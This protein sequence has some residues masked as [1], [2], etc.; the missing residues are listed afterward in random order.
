MLT[1]PFPP[2]I[3]IGPG[4]FLTQIGGGVRLNPLE[5]SLR[6][7]FGA[8]PLS[9][10]GPF[11]ATVN[12]RA[13]VSFGDPITFTFDGTGSLLEIALAE[14]HFVVNTDGYASLRAGARFDFEI[15]SGRGNI[16]VTLDGPNKQFLADVNGDVE[17]AGQSFGGVEALA[18][19]IGFGGCY[20]LLVAELGFGYRWGDSLPDLMFPSCDLS[21]YKPMA[22]GGTGTPPPGATGP[23]AAGSTFDVKPGTPSVSIQVD[24]D[25][26]LPQVVL[27]D[28]DG[29]RIEPLLVQPPLPT[30]PEILK[31]L[32]AMALPVSATRE[33]I[34]I[35]GPKA[36]TWR[37]EPA[38]GAAA[39]RAA[40]AGARPRA[41]AAAIAGLQI[42]T[43]LPAPT[44]SARVSGNG[45]SRSLAYRATR[46][47]GL[48]VTFI[49]RG[50][51]GTRVIGRTRPAGNGTVQFSTGDLPAGRRTVVAVVQQDGAPRLRK[52]VASYTA[53]APPRPA[54]VGGVAVQRGGGGIV[55]RWKGARAAAGYVV[56]VTIG[57]GRKIARVVGPGV[58]SLR[59]PRVSAR[60]AASATVAGRT[61]AGR[62]GPAGRGAAKAV[63]V[64]RA[65]QRR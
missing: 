19:N 30:D 32:R 3:A 40:T 49:E 47:A 26:G 54:R 10:S 27:V 45:T 60:Y 31:L 13:T 36:G 29:D 41:H 55:V 5:L 15:V 14:E 4:V 2:G 43:G 56:R 51:G 6:G 52:D 9:P 46:R 62:L 17:I 61:R 28:P 23:L 8:I 16:E 21:A 12:G 7:Q 39:V 57:D 35:V 53:P 63:A 25:G 33:T 65:K 38:A 24:G 50:R 1:P 22:G 58:R 42:A 59:V 11:T 44:V 18:S 20:E 34:G 37:I 64:K 48:T